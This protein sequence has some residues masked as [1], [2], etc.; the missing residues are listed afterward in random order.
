MGDMHIEDFKIIVNSICLNHNQFKTNN[1]WEEKI[2]TPILDTELKYQYRTIL[3]NAST[4]EP[5][6]DGKYKIVLYGSGTDSTG[7][8]IFDLN[9]GIVYESNSYSYFGMDYNVNSSL[10]IINPPEDVIKYWEYEYNIIPGW[11]QVEYL[12]IMNGELKVLLIINPINN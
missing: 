1:I 9:T 3:N 5:D 12:T 11:V 7:Y 10:L 6:F 2:Y 4:M 8:F